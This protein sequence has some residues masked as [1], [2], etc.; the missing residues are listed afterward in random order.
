[1]K[2]KKIYRDKYI[3]DTNKSIE[4]TITDITQEKMQIDNNG[5]YHID[6][7]YESWQTDKVK[8]I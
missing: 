2:Q 6:I 5:D 8:R 7:K 3:E 1:M 4:D